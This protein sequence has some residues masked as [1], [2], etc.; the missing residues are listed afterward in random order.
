MPTSSSAPTTTAL[1]RELAQRVESAP[2]TGKRQAI[3]HALNELCAR[4]LV[5]RWETEDRLRRQW[6]WLWGTPETDPRYAEREQIWLRG[7]RSYESLSDAIMAVES[8]LST[9][10][11]T[12]E[13]PPC[14]F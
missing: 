13:M 1:L 7:L 12:Q 11:P 4:A 8:L 9:V 6:D 14:P 10:F 5:E 2:D 3:A